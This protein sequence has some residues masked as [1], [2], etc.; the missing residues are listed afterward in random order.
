LV[1][2]VGQ[3][4]LLRLAADRNDGGLMVGR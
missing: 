3:G 1:G 2:D 4:L